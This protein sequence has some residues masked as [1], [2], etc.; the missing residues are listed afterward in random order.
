MKLWTL[1]APF[2]SENNSQPASPAYSRHSAVPA[3]SFKD[4]S[5]EQGFFIPELIWRSLQGCASWLLC[6]SP[7]L[8]SG[9]SFFPFFFGEGFPLNP[10][11]QKK[12]VPFFPPGH[13]AWESHPFSRAARGAV[14]LP[15]AHAAGAAGDAALGPGARFRTPGLRAEIWQWWSNPFGDPIGEL[16][17]HFRL[18][19]LVVG[20]VDVHWGY[21]RLVCIEKPRVSL[22]FWR[23]SSKDPRKEWKFGR[24]PPDP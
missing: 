6:S 14:L 7:Q 8:P 5:A 21:D 12:K 16:T 9:L 19:I 13:W 2:A 17:T 11:N 24:F 18:P 3:V 15:G 23:C 4:S 10:T 22:K 1:L 20:L